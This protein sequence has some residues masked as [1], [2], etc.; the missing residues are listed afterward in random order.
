MPE[1]RDGMHDLCDEWNARAQRYATE[2]MRRN[3]G[4]DP[5]GAHA[6]GMFRVIEE[7]HFDTCGGRL[8]M[9]TFLA[10]TFPVYAEVLHTLVE[11]LDKA[12]FSSTPWDPVVYGGMALVGFAAGVFHP[13]ARVTYNGEELTI[14]E[15]KEKF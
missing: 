15:M 3:E 13:P 4:L 11:S 9:G 14:N 8:T 12:K 7:N 10:I 1:R 2:S 6:A 5:V